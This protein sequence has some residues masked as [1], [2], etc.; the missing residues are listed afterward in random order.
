MG[1]NIHISSLR[2]QLLYSGW[3]RGAVAEDGKVYEYVKQK[4]NN[5]ITIK[6]ELTNSI[7]SIHNKQLNIG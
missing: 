2:A 3:K 5:V 1:Y 7:E 4:Y 6:I